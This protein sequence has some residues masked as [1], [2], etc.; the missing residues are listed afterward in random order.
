MKMPAEILGLSP[1]GCSLKEIVVLSGQ[2]D[3]PV[4]HSQGH[5]R[6]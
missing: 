1:T 5:W 3:W 2:D 6:N 4:V